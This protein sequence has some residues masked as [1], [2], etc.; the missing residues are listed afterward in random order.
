MI[1]TLETPRLTLRGFTP[2]DVEAFAG[3][4]AS[5]A[6]RFVGGPEDLVSTWK[7][8]AAY[9]GCWSLRGYGKFVVVE[10]MSGQTVGIVGPTFPEGWPEPE[11]G[12]TVL[13]EFEGR[14]YAAEAAI[15]AITFAYDEL[16]WTTAMSAIFPGNNRSFRLA[17]RLGASHEGAVEV[18][19]HGMLEIWRH[20]PP[21]DFRAHSA[22]MPSFLRM[23]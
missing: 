2:G 13:P 21:A 17:E 15:R 11:I 19:P 14:G 9:A 20:L 22:R 8:I 10:R 5:E 4:Y 6:S 7:R 3:F 12:W 18:K 1:P 23:Q 16:G